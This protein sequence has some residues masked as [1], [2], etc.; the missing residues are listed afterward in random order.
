MKT[1]GLI[2]GNGPLPVLFAREARAKGYSV[3]AVGHVEESVAELEQHVAHM[4]W[5]RVGEIETLIHVLREN[6][7]R[8]VVMLGAID[9]K[10]A[11]KNPKLDARALKVIQRLV[12]RG[13]DALLSALA[14]ELE[15]EGIEVMGPE[16]LL[17]PLISP[18]GI[19][20]PRN[21]D[22]RETQDLRLG[23][24]VLEKV[25]SMDVGQTVVVKEG[26]ILALE[27]IEGTDRTIRR[28]GELGGSGAV[29]V[30]GSKP[31]QDLR[32][33]LPVVGCETVQSLEDA[34]ATVLAVEAGRTILLDRDEMMAKA[35]KA[36]ICIVGWS[37]G[38][39]HD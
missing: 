2:A 10:R 5:V 19:F 22:L 27:A 23:I 11:L 15:S 7:V 33:D 28:G 20:S 1:L 3:V 32:F 16:N 6:G 36:G 25:G 24:Q 12:G 8:Q 29:V 34:G 39:D 14:A 17:A 26:V 18:P 4:T 30:K 38:E 13:D 21:L 37:R 9:K 35:E 31:R